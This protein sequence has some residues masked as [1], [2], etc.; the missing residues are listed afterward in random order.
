MAVSKSEGV[1]V[2]TLTKLH[3]S[4]SYAAL[5]GLCVCVCVC[6][7][8]SVCLSVC[9]YCTEVPTSLV[10]GTLSSSTPS[11]DFL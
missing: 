1:V 5:G 11:C 10:C 2:C 7:C 9:K 4:H 8:L 3:N 6:V